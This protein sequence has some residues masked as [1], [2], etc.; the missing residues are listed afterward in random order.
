[1]KNRAL[2]G[3]LALLLASCV[4]PPTQ[5]EQ[6]T[7]KA[8]APDHARYVNADPAL[9]PM[10]K[11]RRLDLLETW[12]IRV[13]VPKVPPVTDVPSMPA[14]VPAPEEAPK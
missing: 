11:Q 6:L 10:A 8:I 5:A 9:D 14:P 4:L 13:G 3:L 2:V 1:M 7:Y 12:R